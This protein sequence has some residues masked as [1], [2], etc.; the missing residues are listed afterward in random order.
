MYCALKFQY[1]DLK[2]WK[3]P[4]YIFI[5]TLSRL[6]KHVSKTMIH[7]CYWVV[8][9]VHML[10][11]CAYCLAFLFFPV[12]KCNVNVLLC[13]YEW[14]NVYNVSVSCL[15]PCVLIMTSLNCL[16]L[17]MLFSLSIRHCQSMIQS[18]VIW[19]WLQNYSED[20]QHT[21]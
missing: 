2:T 3:K 8:S 16:S 18:M 14:L 4:F 1:P 19:L 12:F 21:K 15:W 20:R 11:F 6:V 10:K 13:Y 7:V 17:L 9:L 5:R